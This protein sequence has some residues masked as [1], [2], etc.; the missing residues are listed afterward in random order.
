MKGEV[1][2][3]SND[4]GEDFEQDLFE[5]SKES[6]EVQERPRGDGLP[7]VELLPEGTKRIT[8][9]VIRRRVNKVKTSQL[10]KEQID[11]QIE[12]SEIMAATGRVVS[13]P[14]YRNDSYDYH[15]LMPEIGAPASIE[16]VPVG[17]PLV[18]ANVRHLAHD[19]NV[20][21][22][23]TQDA[24]TERA[25][26]LVDDLEITPNTLVFVISSPAATFEIGPIGSDEAPDI[27]SR[28]DSTLEVIRAV[29]DKRGVRHTDNSLGE[30]ESN[31][32]L[33]ARFRR[34][35]D[36]FQISDSKVNREVTAKIAAN[37]AALGEGQLIPYPEAPN[38]PPTVYASEAPNLQDLEAKTGM[39]EVAS[40]S[41]A[42]GLEGFDILEDH[43]LRN[44]NIPADVDKVVVILGRHG[45][46]CTNVSEALLVATDG[47]H[48]IAFAENGGYAMVQACLTSTGEIVEDY[49]V[50]SGL[51]TG[52]TIK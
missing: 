7:Y 19:N 27:N 10:K 2:D 43:F 42:H 49:I 9:R 46:F 34:S 14:D 13:Y 38:V 18:I 3:T 33:T 51:R 28:T 37:R 47:N 4:T 32:L 6:G 45:Q 25:T 36:E 17:P 12:F 30:T 26:N 23:E 20:V 21:S 35:L 8:T 29:L 5:P 1:T 39:S 31:N 50:E 16:A 44:G 24:Y 15:Q 11:A 48:P 22:P 41:V 40:A 52:M